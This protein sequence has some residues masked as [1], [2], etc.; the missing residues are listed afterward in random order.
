MFLVGALP[1]IRDFGF[2][3][4]IAPMVIIIVPPLFIFFIRLFDS[5][6]VLPTARNLLEID[7]ARSGLRNMPYFFK[8][9]SGHSA[10]FD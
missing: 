8:R 4:D 2:E 10:F 1:Q 5:L 3:I 6:R 7:L 9:A